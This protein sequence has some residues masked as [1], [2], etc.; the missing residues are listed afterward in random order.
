[1]N[2][3]EIIKNRLF[4]MV[5]IL[6]SVIIFVLALNAS[7]T[8]EAQ[9]TILFLPKTE[10]TVLNINQIIEN[11]KQLSRKEKIEAKQIGKSGMLKLDVSSETQIK[12][13]SLG[14]Q[15][16][17]EL[18][19]TMSGYYNVKTDLDMRIVGKP[20]VAQIVKINVGLWI[21]LSLLLGFAIGFL[22]NSFFTILSQNDLEKIAEPVA[23]K[24]IE[25][26]IAPI[27]LPKVSFSETRVEKSG[28]LSKIR[29]IF[30][31]NTEGEASLAQSKKDFTVSEK[32]AAAPANLPIAEEDP[33]FSFS[34]ETTLPEVPAV[35][36]IDEIKEVK[37]VETMIAEAAA[38]DTTR[39]AT[40]EEVK[41]R[42]NKLLSGD[43]LK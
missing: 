37:P 17:R 2:I 31:F 11:A 28:N 21:F 3:K 34:N 22:F 25:S 33:N 41:A 8:F 36:N 10:V 16:T 1:M 42:L 7:K 12:A 23:E 30:N 18:L 29:N 14:R 9:T 24:S 19:D 38:V 40:P 26:Q 20:T 6:L 35:E 4:W 13:E 32:K 43:M 15:T 5:S 39:E 27:E